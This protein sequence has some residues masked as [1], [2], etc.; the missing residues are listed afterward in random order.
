MTYDPNN[1][2]A[3]IL[4]GEIPNKTVYES[5]H[6]LAFHD[7]HPHAAVHVLVI[8]KGG[9]INFMDFTTRASADEIIGFHYAVAKVAEILGIQDSGFRLITNNGTH[10]GQEVP[11]FHVHV[12]GGEKLGAMVGK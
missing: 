9:Y 11:H 5:G 7:I 6:A 2:F 4:R 12:L 8:P 1:I 10:G 3:K